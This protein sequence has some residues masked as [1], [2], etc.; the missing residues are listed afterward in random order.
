MCDDKD[1]KQ[2][3]DLYNQLDERGKKKFEY[4]VEYYHFFKGLEPEEINRLIE[5]ELKREDVQN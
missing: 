3:L 4:F 2:I 1:V 5:E